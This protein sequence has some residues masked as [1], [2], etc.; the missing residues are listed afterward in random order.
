MQATLGLAQLELGRK[1]GQPHLE[2]RCVATF[3]KAST[4]YARAGL[5]RRSAACERLANKRLRV[6]QDGY[7]PRSVREG[8]S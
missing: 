8:K 3:L 6:I 4:F 7:V 1:F 5:G 2:R